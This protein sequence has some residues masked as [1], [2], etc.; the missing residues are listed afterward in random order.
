MRVQPLSNFALFF[1]A[2]NLLFFADDEDEQQAVRSGDENENE[3]VDS[4]CPTTPSLST[5]S[6]VLYNF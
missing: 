5:K 1:F 3:N 6:I 2:E 4:S